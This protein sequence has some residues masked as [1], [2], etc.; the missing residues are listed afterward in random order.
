MCGKVKYG[1]HISLSLISTFIFLREL[2]ST[3]ARLCHLV[4]SSTSDMEQEMKQLE[5]EIQKLEE[6]TA[7]AKLL[8]NKAN[9]LINELDMFDSAYLS[10]K[11]Q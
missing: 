5:S 4:D 10:E 9:Y 6:L 1:P 2:S 11:K 8:K 7:S 3:F